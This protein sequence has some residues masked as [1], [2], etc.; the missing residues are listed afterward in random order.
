M[1]RLLMW[2]ARR[3]PFVALVIAGGMPEAGRRKYLDYIEAEQSD[4]RYPPASDE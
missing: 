2:L 1:N 4:T 3:S